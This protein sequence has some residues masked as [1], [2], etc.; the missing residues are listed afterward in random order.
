MPRLPLESM[1]VEEKLALMEEL[2]ADLCSRAEGMLTPEWHRHIL[3]ERAAAVERG[4]ME[5][6]D[7]DVAKRRI[8]KEIE[9][10]RES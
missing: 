2:W 6:E 7:F 4:E 8:L 5:Y 3:D 10:K 9:K 1:S